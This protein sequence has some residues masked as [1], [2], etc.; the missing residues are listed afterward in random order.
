[1]SDNGSYEPLSLTMHIEPYKLPPAVLV[2]IGTI[3]T[4]AANLDDILSMAIFR[5]SE[6]APSDGFVMLGQTTMPAKIQKL[7]YLAK[8]YTDAPDA[9]RIHAAC[10]HLKKIFTCRNAIAHGVYLGRHKERKTLIFVTTSKNYEPEDGV[11]VQKAVGYSEEQLTTMAAFATQMAAAL[12]QD[13][14]VLK[15]RA[16]RFL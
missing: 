8:K 12:E 9:E 10:G 4:A 15:L 5:V 2:D 7:E 11:T 16:E 1:M 13:F 6:I 14:D 3:V